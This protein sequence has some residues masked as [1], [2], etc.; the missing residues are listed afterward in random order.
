MVELLLDTGWLRNADPPEAAA[1]TRCRDGSKDGHKDGV[2]SWFDALF[3]HPTSC[4]MIR[5]TSSKP[6]PTIYQFERSQCIASILVKHPSPQNLV[7]Q[8]PQPALRISW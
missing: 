5:T 7:P 8:M 3:H 4:I 1:S 6:F 2:E